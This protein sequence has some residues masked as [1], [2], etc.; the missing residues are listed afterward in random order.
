M[1][2]SRSVPWWYWLVSM[3]AL[4]WGILGCI[5]VISE[6]PISPAD[7][8]KSPAAQKASWDAMPF[9]VAACYVVSA[10]LNLIGAILLLR[11]HSMA[12]IAYFVAGTFVL[13][14]YA[15]VLFVTPIFSE[16]A[17]LDALAI[18]LLVLG[19]SLG[20]FLFAAWGAFGDWFR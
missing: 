13:V 17:V 8:D 1:G 14:Q 12:L 18:P 11:R 10:Q 3:L 20:L 2:F 5:A 9:S 6:V 4:G 15:Y 7:Y 16:M 19:V